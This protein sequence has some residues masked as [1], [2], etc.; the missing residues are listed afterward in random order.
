MSTDRIEFEAPANIET[1]HESCRSVA[2]REGWAI[3]Q[4]EPVRLQIDTGTVEGFSTIKLDVNLAPISDEATTVRVD[5]HVPGPFVKHD[6]D[7][8]M[9]ELQADVIAALG[10]S[11]A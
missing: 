6:L 4:S 5:A 9:N 3:K 8:V 2:E 1:T 11:N 7:V 10:Q